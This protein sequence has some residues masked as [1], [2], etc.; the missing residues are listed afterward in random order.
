MTAAERQRT[1]ALHTANIIRVENAALK[2]QIQ[3]LGYIDGCLRVAEI[4]EEPV[5]PGRLRVIDGPAGAIR[6]GQ[7]LTSVSRLGD[8][9][10]GVLCRRAGIT[11]RD[12][13]VR[14]LTARQRTELA[15]GLRGIPA[16][17][18]REFTRGY[19]RGL[20][21]GVDP[22]EWRDAAWECRHG[23]LGCGECH[24]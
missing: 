3:A 15:S 23:R 18:A 17:M 2:Q 4:L 1:D 12:R 7:L 6:V 24:S 8:M 19:R 20:A 16:V 9:R 13:R 21:A 22:L 5:M 10:A 14:E 11:S